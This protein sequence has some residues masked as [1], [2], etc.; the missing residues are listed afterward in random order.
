VSISNK[1][2]IGK[3]AFLVIPFSIF[4]LILHDGGSGGHIGGG[5]YDLSGLVYGLALF[6]CIGV[7]M[8]WMLICLLIKKT[9]SDRK[10]YLKLF[11]IG[12]L[13]LIAAYFI[14]PRMF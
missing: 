8:I 5:G 4:T 13:A 1:K 3:L 12:I 10:I 11:L 14:T 9:K 2:I 6:A 7:W